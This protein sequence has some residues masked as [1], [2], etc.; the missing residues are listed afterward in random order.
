MLCSIL[1]MHLSMRSGIRGE[2][3]VPLGRS[4]AQVNSISCTTSCNLG[5]TMEMKMARLTDNSD[6]TISCLKGPSSRQHDSDARN[7]PQAQIALPL[8]SL[9]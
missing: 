6:P 8:A 9:S 4:L 3:T 1:Y 5:A 7:R 2:M